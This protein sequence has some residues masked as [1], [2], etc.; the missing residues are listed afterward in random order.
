MV[1]NG[2]GD[3]YRI[4]AVTQQKIY[5]AAQQLNYQPNI[6]ARRLRSGGE[7]V[8]PIIALFWS[9]DTRTVLINR[10][11]KGL[12][13]C[14]ATLEQEYELL[15]QPYV[16]TK[17]QEVRSLLTGT[18]YNGA[19]IANATEA[20]EQFLEQA[21]P[22]VPL[23]L[24]QRI[25]G[26]YSCVHVD[27][28]RTGEAVAELFAGRGHRTIGALVPDVS[29]KA[30][31][32]RL[33]GFA[34]RARALGMSLSPEHTVHADFSEAGGYAAIKQLLASSAG[35]PTAVFTL[36][37]QMSVGALMALHEAGLQVPD[38][39]ELMG[40][41][42][43]EVTRFTIPPLSTVHLPVEEMAAECVLLLTDLMQHKSRTQVDK[44]FESHL[45]I[46]KSCGGH[47]GQMP[48][49]EG[50]SAE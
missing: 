30:I 33:E 5:E 13:D 46:R 16:G 18:R 25:S 2:K 4:S 49:I 38:D 41:D 20:D 34:S 11:L 43:D 8:L 47:G 12:Q 21:Q 26:K 37:D 6:S 27:S 44:R 36:S 24:Y 29:S 40:H 50:H 32:L 1:L 14:L 22:M 10:F 48:F 15:I 42:N 19:I 23:V 7:T 3:L 9:L 45:V 17:L 35:L 28:F 39:M 31:R